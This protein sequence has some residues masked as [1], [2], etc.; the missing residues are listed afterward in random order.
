MTRNRTLE[1]S[2]QEDSC[3]SPAFQGALEAS[4]GSLDYMPLSAVCRL[5]SSLLQEREAVTA[6]QP[7]P[8]DGAK[9]SV[10]DRPCEAGVTAQVLGREELLIVQGFMS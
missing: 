2:A 10:H 9:G 8:P 5:V 1:M 7:L 6:A 4:I 3:P